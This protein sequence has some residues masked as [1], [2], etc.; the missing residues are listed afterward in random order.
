MSDGILDLY[1]DLANK[2]LSKMVSL[3]GVHTV[4]ILV[5]RAVWITSQQYNEADCI[6]FDENGISL[7]ALET[8]AEPERIKEVVEAFFESLVG[9]LTRLVGSNITERIAQEIDAILK[10]ENFT[11]ER[12]ST[13]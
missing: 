10:I 5:Q 4:T 6:K 8:M 12:N 2:T 1:N 11:P 13:D 3:V 7:H 9:I